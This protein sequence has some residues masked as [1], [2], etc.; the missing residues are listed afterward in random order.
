MSGVRISPGAPVYL[1]RNAILVAACHGFVRRRLA[2]AGRWHDSV[3]AQVFHHLAIMIEA[4][5]DDERGHRKAR[6]VSLSK[7]ILD[8]THYVLLV[9]GRHSPLHISKGFIHVFENLGFG[10]ERRRTILLFAH[11]RWRLLSHHA[12][13]IH[14]IRASYAFQLLSAGV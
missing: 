9:D 4:V 6:G 1:D 11:I 8:G 13:R 7:G 12:G 2:L 14:E 5:A 10:L 3:H